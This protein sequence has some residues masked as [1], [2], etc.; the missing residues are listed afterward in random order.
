MKDAH[1]LLFAAIVVHSSRT[2]AIY[3]GF[4][5]VIVGLMWLYLSW[6]ILLLGVQ[7][8]FYVQHPQLLRP[9]QAEILGAVRNDGEGPQTHQGRSREPAETVAREVEAAIKDSMNGRTL[10]DLVGAEGAKG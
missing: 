1:V 7:L 10:K 9:G 6:L 3:A 2:M 4:A 8:A 5:S